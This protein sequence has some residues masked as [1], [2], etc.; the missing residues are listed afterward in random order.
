MLKYYLI[1]KQGP[2]HL[3]SALLLMCPYPDLV[4]GVHF[5]SGPLF[6]SFYCLSWNCGNIFVKQCQ[7]QPIIPDLCEAY[8]VTDPLFSVVFTRIFSFETTHFSVVVVVRSCMIGPM[9]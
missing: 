2:I 6:S 8:L 3:L 7:D 5:S 1:F 4:L 9:L